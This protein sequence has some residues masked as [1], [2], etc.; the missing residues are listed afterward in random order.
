MLCQNLFFSEPSEVQIL[1]AQ[2]QSVTDLQEV[3]ISEPLSVCSSPS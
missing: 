1:I 2:I 3:G